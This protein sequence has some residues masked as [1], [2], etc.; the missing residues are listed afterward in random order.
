MVLLFPFTVIILSVDGGFSWCILW[1]CFAGIGTSVY[2][3]NQHGITP[4]V[5]CIRRIYIYIYIYWVSTLGVANTW[6]EK[7][8]KD[9]IKWH[10]IIC[11]LQSDLS[12]LIKNSLCH[13]LYQWW[14]I[15][16]CRYAAPSLNVLSHQTPVTHLC[17]SKLDYL[18]LTSL[19]LN[20][21]SIIVNKTLRNIY[22]WNFVWKWLVIIQENAFENF[23]SASMC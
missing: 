18:Y 13:Y 3:T 15:H 12:I 21:Y 8:I 11:F 7:Y 22:Q 19:Y 23:A 6:D 20:Q 5:S 1:C 9:G 14:P 10:Y 4:Q 2:F 16:R 17:I